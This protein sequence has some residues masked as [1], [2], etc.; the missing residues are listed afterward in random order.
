MCSGKDR[1]QLALAAP[2]H[3][4][5]RFLIFL[6]NCSLGLIILEITA[7]VIL[8]ENGPYWH[9]LR[10]GDLT[11]INFG[12]DISP[13]LVDL[14]RS[15]LD[16]NPVMRPTPDAIL[17][18]PYVAQIVAARPIDGLGAL[19]IPGPGTHPAAGLPAAASG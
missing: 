10:Q 18:H 17:V 19:S 15:M 14:V 16:P 1:L 4:V 13:A 12:Q 9:K 3:R 11:E 6:T 5:T 2:V 8:P 7:N